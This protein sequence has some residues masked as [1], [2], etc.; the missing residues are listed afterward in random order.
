MNP[1]SCLFAV[2]LL[3][4]GMAQA[5]CYSVYKADGTLLQQSSTTPVDLT[6]PIGDTVT[7]KFGPG[8]SMTVSDLAIYC[9]DKREVH[10]GPKSLAE[11]VRQESEKSA[12][13]GRKKNAEA[14]EATTA[15]R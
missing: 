6:E 11:S 2:A 5:A 12:G 4:A 10:A 3:T 13:V 14:V 7:A 9:R 15:A 8:A 1:K